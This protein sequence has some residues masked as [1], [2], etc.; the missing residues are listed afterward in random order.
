IS[1]HQLL[2]FQT[3]FEAAIKK[4]IKINLPVE[5]DAELR[6]S[7]E[8]K[9]VLSLLEPIG[10]GNPAPLL[11]VK[12]FKLRRAQVMKEIHLKLFGIHQGKE[13]S[14]LHFKS[15]WVRL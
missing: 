14:V 15:P 11:M 3:E 12:G 7:E 2:R 1:A 6:S 9:D 4:Q 5:V 8:L 13:W 10:N